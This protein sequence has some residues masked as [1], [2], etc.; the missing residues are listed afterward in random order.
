MGYKIT[1]NK[2][3][4]VYYRA[5]NSPMEFLKQAFWYGYGRKLIDLKHGNIWKKH[6]TIDILKTQTTFLGYIYCAI[7]IRE[8]SLKAS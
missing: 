5:R 1:E 2:K 6:S 3:A 7:T 4:I 8:Y